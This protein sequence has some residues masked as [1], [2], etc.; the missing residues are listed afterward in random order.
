M[1]II[2]FKD[3]I[4]I[5]SDS[6]ID[7]S[8]LANIKDE[9]ICDV[10]AYGSKEIMDKYFNFYKDISLFIQKYGIVGETLLYYYLKNNNISYELLEIK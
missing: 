9:Y 1:K 8:K 10:L 6:K 2:S 5:P 4:Y 3:I 7:K